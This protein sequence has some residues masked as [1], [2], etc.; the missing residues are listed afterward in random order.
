MKEWKEGKA[1]RNIVNDRVRARIARIKLSSPA[2]IASRNQVAAD[3]LRYTSPLRPRPVEQK[4]MTNEEPRS[5]PT[6]SDGTLTGS[7]A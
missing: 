5:P 7:K 3:G 4:E 1:K 6:K 2:P